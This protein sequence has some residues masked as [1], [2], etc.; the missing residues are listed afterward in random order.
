MGSSSD[1]LVVRLITWLPVGG[2][3][4]RLVSVLPRLVERGFRARVVCLREEGALAGELREAGI[5]VDVLR[6]RSRLDPV[7]IRTLAGMLK[8]WGASVVHSHM[9]RSNVP[10]TLAARWAR[11][12]VVFSQVHNI[13][14]WETPRQAWL[15]R[16]LCRWRTGVVCVS[17]A[18]QQDVCARL[19]LPVERAPILYNGC[20]TE[21]FRPDARV[22]SETRRALGLTEEEVALLVP[23]RLHSQ[24]RPLEVLR[25]FEAASAHAGGSGRLLFAGAGPMEERL[26]EAIRESGLEERVMMLGRRDDMAALYN[27]A[28]GVVLSS[29]REGFS[30]AVIEALACGKPVIAADVG[31]NR[32]AVDSTAVGW[33]HARADDAAL[34]Q[35]M[36][37]ALGNLGALRAREADCRTRGLAFGLNALVDATAELYRKALGGRTPHP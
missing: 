27:A 31:G 13:D 33:I 24:K 12:P 35:Q 15:D 17:R 30:N 32:E 14:T 34:T 11:T 22:R 25:A 28:D 10:G 8:S 37:E 36:E 29:E 18:V 1:P 6:L 21:V 7:R 3:E 9:Y 20:D 5:P 16:Q 2:I 4:R 23:A 26:R 19:R